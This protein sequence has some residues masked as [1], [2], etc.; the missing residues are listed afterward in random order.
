MFACYAEALPTYVK[1][2]FINGVA[3]KPVLL[4]RQVTTGKVHSGVEL[5]A[6]D[7]LDEAR[8]QHG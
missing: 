4:M 8:S 6:A 1:I 3:L 5:K 2:M 7:E